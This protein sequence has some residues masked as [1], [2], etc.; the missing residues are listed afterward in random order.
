L[1]LK[2][3]DGNDYI[4][5]PAAYTT[6]NEVYKENNEIVIMYENAHNS[7]NKLTIKLCHVIN[8]GVTHTDNKYSNWDDT[9]DED[10]EKYSS[11]MNLNGV[12]LQ[13]E[14]L[15]GKIKVNRNY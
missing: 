9:K 10:I 2:A 12:G 3:K 15:V 5:F 4:Y 7:S 1:D 14:N 11:W 13:Y 8:I 6:Y